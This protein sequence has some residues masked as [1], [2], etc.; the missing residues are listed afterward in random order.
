MNVLKGKSVGGMYLFPLILI[1]L[2]V[3]LSILHTTPGQESSVTNQIVASLSYISALFMLLKNQWGYFSFALKRATPLLIM[4]FLALASIMWTDFPRQLLTGFVHKLGA[5]FVTICAVCLLIND[6]EAF[7]RILLKIL[8]LY[9]I[10]TILFSF[11]RPDMAEMPAT[12]YGEYRAGLRGFTL[13]PNT[14]GAIWVDGV[15]VAM[16]YLYLTG[17]KTKAA[18]LM[19]TIMLTSIVYCLVKADSM[20][21]ILVSLALGFIVFWLKFIQSENSS[22]KALKIMSAL[23]FLLI[24]TSVLIVIKPHIF[25]ID[26]FFKAIGR[27][28]TFTGRTELWELAMKGFAEKPVFGWGE[29]NLFTFLKFYHQPFS[30]LHNGYFDLLVRGGVVSVLLFLTMLFKIAKSVLRMLKANEQ[31]Y[32]IVLSFV[33]VWLVHNV[34]E[35]S[36]FKSP[37]VLWLFFMLLYFYSITW[38][39]YRNDAGIALNKMA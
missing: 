18:K 32:I 27:N 1:F 14:L 2:L 39:Y 19:V 11:V 35:A 6:K 36:I 4:L 9:F 37:N 26:F 33:S 17:A 28:S 25:S 16:C 3:G 13:H 15:W 20:T 8:L 22:V 29:D 30:Q 10:A 38:T 12:L 5:V 31:N 21:S 7:F 23:F 24:S 34:T